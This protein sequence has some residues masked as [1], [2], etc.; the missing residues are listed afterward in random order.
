[1]KSQSAKSFSRM[2]STSIN[3]DGYYYDDQ[4]ET[5]IKKYDSSAKLSSYFS[6]DSMGGSKSP[7]DSKS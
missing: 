7:I 2:S 4:S 5:S 6:R 3:H 1:M